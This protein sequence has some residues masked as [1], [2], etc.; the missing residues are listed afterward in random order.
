MRV[1]HRKA[2]DKEAGAR[3]RNRLPPYIQPSKAAASD[4]GSHP[5]HAFAVFGPVVL[6]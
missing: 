4:G 2:S 3:T 1:V 5:T 6:D